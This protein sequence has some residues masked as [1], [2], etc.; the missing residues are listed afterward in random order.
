MNGSWCSA[1]RAGGQLGS[2]REPKFGVPPR[3]GGRH[4][5]VKPLAPSSREGPVLTVMELDPSRNERGKVGLFS[6]G[7]LDAPLKGQVCTTQTCHGNQYRSSTGP[8]AS[9]SS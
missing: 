3:D 4:A 9:P 1:A 7:R 6:D 8:T 5:W 2:G